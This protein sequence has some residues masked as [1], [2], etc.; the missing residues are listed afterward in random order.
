[1]DEKSL[2][3]LRK[4]LINGN[5][6]PL[7]KIY[8]EFKKDCLKVIQ[9]RK[10]HSES[11]FQDIYTEAVIIFRNNI[12]SGKIEELSSVKN[13]LISTCV[14]ISRQHITKEIKL[15]SKEAEV[16]H[17][18]YPVDE[19]YS[20]KNDIKED[21]IKYCKESLKALTEKCQKILVLYY[22]HNLSMKEIAAELE[23]SS[24][25]VTKTMKSRCYR[26]WVAK[27]KELMQ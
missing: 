12:I 20:E 8:M 17:L 23:F 16:R 5:N 21:L 10:A 18:L 25:D 14:N 19:P 7:K 24:S 4:D 22:V 9:K 3:Q 1:L 6:K 26:K 27:T 15:K 2:K 13:Y 11:E